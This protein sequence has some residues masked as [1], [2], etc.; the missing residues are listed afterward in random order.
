MNLL[1]TVAIPA[2]NVENY[3]Q[4]TLDSMISPQQEEAVEIIIVDDGSTD[5]TGKIADA[6]ALQY[7]CIRVV[8][9]SNGGHGAAINTGIREAKGKYFKLIDGD[10]WVDTK[11]FAGFIDLLARIEADLIICDYCQVYTKRK[12]M[13][14]YDFP[15]G[16]NLSMSNLHVDYLVSMHACTY[17]TELLKQLPCLVDEHC[18]YV[19]MEY[20]LYPLPFLHSFRYEKINLYQYRLGRSGQ[21]VS[22]EGFRRH[23]REDA[24]V[25]QSLVHY[26]HQYGKG[27]VE[28]GVDYY[29]PQRIFDMYYRHILKTIRAFD[30]GKIPVA[31]YLREFDRHFQMIAPDLYDFY[32]KIDSR[33]K[34]LS[35]LQLWALRKSGF[36]LWPLVR[37]KEAM[38]EKWEQR[39]IRI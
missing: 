16:V 8:H 21:S 17:R 37:V 5:G 15:A 10:D 27:T 22:K 20:L 34:S 25:L 33:K 14:S 19:D 4:Q 26:Y 18:Y 23:Y 30:N 35:A 39:T 13:V 6:Y 32:R 31:K 29:M 24:G 11:G 2:Y 1:L 36:R 28:E 3:I 38:K 7:P 9:Q 12:E